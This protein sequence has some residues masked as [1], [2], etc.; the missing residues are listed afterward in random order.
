MLQK[1]QLLI[2]IRK[3]NVNKLT[4]NTIK[5]SGL[6]NLDLAEKVSYKKILY[7]E[8]FKN[9]E[10]R[11]QVIKKIIKLVSMLLLLIMGLKKIS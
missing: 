3:F 6:K 9:L 11:I 7:L 2:Q 1:E 8:R 10:K 5:W 4:T